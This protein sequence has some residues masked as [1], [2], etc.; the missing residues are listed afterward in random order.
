MK[1]MKPLTIRGMTLRNRVVMPPM[2]TNFRLLNP[3]AR[4]YLVERAKGGVGL[5]IPGALP[6][7]PFRNDKVVKGIV[8]TTSPFSFTS[9]SLKLMPKRPSNRCLLTST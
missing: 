6:V 3:I 9:Q 7:D 2:Q 5:I 8:A 1:L 4:G